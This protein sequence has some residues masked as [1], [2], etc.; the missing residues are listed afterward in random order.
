MA[1]HVTLPS[2]APIILIMFTMQVGNILNANFDAIYNLYNPT[3]YSVADVIDTLVMRTGFEEGHYER[4]TAIG[5]FK[6]VINFMLLLTANTIV[7]K[8]N[9]YGM[10][11]VAE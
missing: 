8:I 2:I 1:R 3:V 10:Y 4:G 11:E 9:G 5:L 7:K 6:S